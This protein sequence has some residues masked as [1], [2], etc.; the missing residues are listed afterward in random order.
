MA[1]STDDINKI[2]KMIE[3][4]TMIKEQKNGKGKR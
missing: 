3:N 2:D 1:I 4:V